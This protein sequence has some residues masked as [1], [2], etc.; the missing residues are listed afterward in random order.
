MAIGDPIA[1]GD[2][3]T[4]VFGGYGS[5]TTI[6]FAKALG[7]TNYRPRVTPTADA[8]YVGNIWISDKTVNGFRVNNSGTGLTAFEWSVEVYP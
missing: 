7:S 3:G 5:Y 4:G 2:K 1:E 8:G 6:T